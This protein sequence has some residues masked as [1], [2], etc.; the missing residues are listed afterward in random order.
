V[1]LVGGPMFPEIV[2]WWYRR[3]FRKKVN[4]LVADL[5]KASNTLETYRPLSELARSM[6]L[7]AEAPA[8]SPEAEANG[9][10]KERERS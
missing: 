4:E 6:E 10:E 5:A 1:L 2:M 9:A 7:Y 3:R 8:V